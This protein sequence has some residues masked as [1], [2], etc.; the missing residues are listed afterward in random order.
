M[1]MSEDINESTK[2]SISKVKKRDG[3]IVD[4]DPNKITEAIFKSA[5][6]SRPN[7]YEMSKKIAQLIMAR[8][9]KIKKD[10]LVLG[11]AETEKTIKE[12]LT[13]EGH[14]ST[15]ENFKIT[16]FSENLD[17][18]KV[19]KLIYE[20]AKEHRLENRAMVEKVT[21]YVLQ[22]ME[23]RFNAH[24]IPS[25]E[26]VQDMVE[27]TLIEHGH[28]KTAKSYILYRQ[29][30]TE[31]R[32]AKSM[33][34]VEDDLKLPLN[35]I[36]ILAARYLRRD[37]NKNI[38]ETPKQLFRRV[39]RAVAETDLL[40]DPNSD[41]TKTEEE[42][43]QM[44]VDFEF[45]PNSPTLM[46][47]GTELGQLSACFVVPI[48]DSIE[49]IFDA[50]KVMAIVQKSGGGTGFSFSRLRPNSD[51]VKST[52][53]VASG[54][55]GFMKV[56]NAA[57]EEIKQGGKRRGAN[58]GI[59]RVDHPD[60]LDF[61]VVKEKENALTN[62][63]LSVGMTDRFMEAVMKDQ[64]YDLL[65]PR[66][67][68]SL[69]RLKARAVWNLLMTMAWKNG[70]PG[71]IFLDKIN[72]FN[73]TPQVGEIE[74]TNPC[75]EQ[76]LLPYE[77][78]NLGSI[79]LIKMVKDGQ[80]DWEKLRKIIRSAVHFLDN[81]IDINKYPVLEIELMTKSNRK[82]G[83][84]VM[85]F[86][87]MLIALSIPYNSV[88][89]LRLA[90]S[91]M[92]FI[93]D[94]GRKM[95]VELAK[96]RGSF[97]N[98]KGSIFERNGYEAMRNATITTVA[99]TGTIGEIAGSSNGIEPLFAIAYIRSVAETLGENLTVIN[100]LFEKT[101]IQD[102]FYS[103]ELIKKIS[104]TTSIQHLE[105]IPERIRKIFIT[106]HDLTPEW[107]VRMQAAFQKYTDNAVSK[108]VNFPNSATPHDIEKVYLLAYQLGCKGV[109]VYRDGSR[110]IQVLKTIAQEERVQEIPISAEFD[111]ICEF[112]SL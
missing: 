106:A 12:I 22:D 72:K 15:A 105:E 45:L 25:V 27:K 68:K 88:T 65:N 50:I 20:V 11:Q 21:T 39:A 92:K 24:T 79:N 17:A 23:K 75:G 29:K 62:F 56:F 32:K 18:E 55:I 109:T 90:E 82:I 43:Y 70:E 74:S 41:V 86:A 37:E 44:M 77:S 100:P 47:A 10:T 83:L 99:P 16:D 76:P 97:T 31:L 8:L 52:S 4:F 36:T 66:T 35:A 111:G 48:P 13:Q 7:N 94:E 51:I 80:M 34:G 85:G 102:E 84:G 96:Q 63:N 107:H 58:M 14:H 108:T 69:K 81:V 61:I 57:T 26:D 3:R 73:P 91:I 42:F 9:E 95:S 78:C 67:G 49:G 64:D 46:N 98:F 28:A 6:A 2:Y 112:C 1:G 101:A 104:R 33:L 5:E 71:I 103:E 19:A 110:K 40:Y 54:P 59:L 30:R 93:L 38:I 60:I 89:A 53:G 87:D